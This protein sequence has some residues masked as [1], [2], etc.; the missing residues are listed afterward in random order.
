MNTQVEQ[1]MQPPERRSVIVR[2]IGPRE[3]RDFLALTQGLYYIITGVWPFISL[4]T[5]LRITG[6]KADVWLVKTAG[7]LVTAIGAA[8]TLAGARERVTPEM[9]IAAVGSAA[10]L[11]GIDVVY[12]LR[13]RI[14]RVYL[15][16]A[17][18][19]V[20]LLV[21]WVILSASRKRK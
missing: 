11:A 3:P 2:H 17:L 21:P 19:E 12:A 15:L 6:P 5:F 18:A 20:A 7:V 1:S 16:E 10:G 9:T 4:G 14:S 13:G 8:L